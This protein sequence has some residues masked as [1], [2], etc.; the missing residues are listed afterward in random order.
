MM[1]GKLEQL[2]IYK[3]TNMANNLVQ[4]LQEIRNIVCG[5]KAHKQPMC[6]MVQLVKMMMCLVQ[7][8]IEGNE[9]YKEAFESLWDTRRNREGAWYITQGSSPKEPSR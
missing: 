2:G 7:G 1:K 9:D 6:S 3:T 4:L 5:R 8:H